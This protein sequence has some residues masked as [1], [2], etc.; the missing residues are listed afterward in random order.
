MMMILPGMNKHYPVL[1]EA[2]VYNI[3]SHSSFNGLE[4][5]IQ[6]HEAL[7]DVTCEPSYLFT[8]STPF[9]QEMTQVTKYNIVIL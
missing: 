5:K 1:Q 3:A 2:T 4:D 8:N 7:F 6:L 9:K